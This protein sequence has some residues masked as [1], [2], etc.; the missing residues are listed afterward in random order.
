MTTNRNIRAF[1]FVEVCM[2]V[3]I[4]SLV[5][6]VAAGIMSYARKETQKGFWI[7]QS[8]S[9]LRNATRQIGVKMKENCDFVTTDRK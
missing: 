6:G 2:S 3:I 8:I 4:L 9:Q 5:F 7:Q 1:T